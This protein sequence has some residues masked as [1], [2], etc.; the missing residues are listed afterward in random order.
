MQCPKVPK[1]TDE[2]RMVVLL[3][4]D[5]FRMAMSLMTGAEI[6]TTNS[7]IAAAK[8][9]KVPMWWRKPV[10]AMFAES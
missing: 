8:K 5:T 3:V 7:R 1:V 10:L 4:R 9:K 2:F 6:D